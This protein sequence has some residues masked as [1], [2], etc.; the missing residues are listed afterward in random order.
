MINLWFSKD[1][2]LIF[3]LSQ[4]GE[5]APQANTALTFA[6]PSHR[7]S[8]FKSQSSFFET[9]FTGSPEPDPNPD[10]ELDPYPKPN[11]TLTHSINDLWD[12]S[13]VWGLCCQRQK[14]PIWG[15][16]IEMSNNASNI[17]DLLSTQKVLIH[18]KIVLIYCWH[19]AINLNLMTVRKQKRVWETPAAGGSQVIIQSVRGREAIILLSL[20]AE[21][22]INL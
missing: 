2:K 10:L 21:W 22:L 20:S 4:C 9:D 15:C 6:V 1:H 16:Q 8:D 13:G 3:I 18:V 5:H 17:N 7:S 14:S 19:P 11:P 12:D